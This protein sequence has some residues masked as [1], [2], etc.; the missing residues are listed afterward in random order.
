[1]ATEIY[2][3]IMEQHSTP[4]NLNP[5]LHRQV[6]MKLHHL[7]DDQLSQLKS[8]MKVYFPEGVE[9]SERSDDQRNMMTFVMNPITE[10]IR[11]RR[12]GVDNREIKT[13]HKKKVAY[14]CVYSHIGEKC[15]HPYEKYCT[16]CLPPLS[17][18]LIHDN[19]GRPFM[20]HLLPNQTVAVYKQCPEYLEEFEPHTIMP[21]F[22][23]GT[24][25]DLLDEFH[26]HPLM[27]IPILE[28][29]DGSDRVDPDPDVEVGC[30]V[31]C[32]LTSTDDRCRYIYIQQ[33]ISL[34]TTREPIETFTPKLGGSDVP[35]PW[36]TTK[37][38]IIL[39][40]H[41]VSISRDSFDPEM[42]DDPYQSYYRQSAK[43]T[44]KM[45]DRMMARKELWM[46]QNK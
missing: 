14:N 36:A 45:I 15:A 22:P 16:S 34:F 41:G 5:K 25:G 42:D 40:L 31:L 46:S 26:P 33:S 32:R 9:W 43:E 21:S 12:V 30:A 35:Y 17:Q 4:D 39:F 44:T 23:Y 18:S 8:M 38:R 28:Y 29:F 24:F 11:G 20:I 37:S 1:M 7:N 13:R 27:T 2:Q 19:G 3:W 6:K 10:A